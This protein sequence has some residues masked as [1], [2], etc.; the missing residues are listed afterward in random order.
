M[1]GRLFFRLSPGLYQCWSR[2][3]EI[4]TSSWCL[5]IVAGA[6]VDIV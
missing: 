6:P 5:R 3:N 4:G 2:V 1:S